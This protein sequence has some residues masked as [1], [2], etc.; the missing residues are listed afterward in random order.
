MLAETPQ[1]ML[2]ATSPNLVTVP[3]H[4]LYLDTSDLTTDLARLLTL[5]LL[6]LYPIYISISLP[7]FRNLFETSKNGHAIQRTACCPGPTLCSQHRH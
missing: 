6:D 4:L 1:E 3:L 5:S 2:G 7:F